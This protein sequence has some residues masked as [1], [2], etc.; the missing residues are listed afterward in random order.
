M[1][2]LTTEYA[3]RAAVFLAE[4]PAARHTSQTIAEATK[5]PMRYMSKV[6]QHLSEAGV[7]DSQR[8]PT[9]GFQLARPADQITL[10]D[11]VQAVEPIERIRSC[12]LNLKAHQ[13]QLCPLHQAMDDLAANA[14]RTLRETSLRDVISEPIVPLNIRGT[15][16]GRD[17][18]E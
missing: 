17:P 3:L 10:L 4:V 5:V 15:F 1:F 11:V 6:L 18:D 2:S 8:G 12:P 14:E 9:G 13:G 7:A 16:T